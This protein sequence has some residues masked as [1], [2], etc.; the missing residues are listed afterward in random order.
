MARFKV[1]GKR[2]LTTI[3]GNMVSVNPGETLKLEG[4]W[5]NDRKF[6]EQFKV[7]RYETVIPATLMGIERYLGSGMIKGIGPV[8]ARR[9]VN[10]F[11]LDTLRIIEEESDKLL[12]VE[13]IGPVRVE[14]IMKAWGEQKEIRNVMLFLQGQGISSAYAVK[15]FK[16]YGNEAIAKVRENPYCLAMDVY[17]IGFKTA[18]K[19][20]ESLGVDKNSPLRAEAGLIYTLQQISDDGH[21][22]YPRKELIS[23]ASELLKIEESILDKAIV[24]LEAHNQIAVEADGFKGLSQ[25]SQTR[26]E[27]FPSIYL[28][29]L[30]AAEVGVAKRLKMLL[31]PPLLPM[32]IDWE[33]ALP[34]LENRMG[35]TLAV[36]QIEALKK[37][38]Q[39]RITVITGGPGTGK[40]TL[41]RCIV[42]ILNQ[43]GL[44]FLLTAP[45]GRAA[46]RLSEATQEDAKT[47]HR[48]LEYSPKDGEFKRN[49]NNPLPVEFLVVDE[50]SMVDIV[51]MNHLLKALPLG[52]SLIFVGDADQLPS[53]GP[54]NVLRDTI[55]SGK[56]EVVRL[57][58]IFRQARESLIVTNAHRINQ[59]VF[60]DLE[61]QQKRGD[62]FFIEK[63]DPEEVLELI[64]KM[65]SE[66]IPRRFGFKPLEDIQVL[67]PMNR[68]LLG[69]HNLNSELQRCLNPHAQE[70]TKSG[71]NFKL[72]DK[73]M[74][75]SNNYEKEVFNGDIGNV[76]RIDLEE[77]E[78]T[79]NF[80][81]RKVIYD[82]NDLDE[83]VVA[84][85]VS[86]HKSQ[87]SEYPAVI[88]PLLTQHYVM[89]QRNLLYTAVTRG[90]RLVVII[91]TKKAL[92]IALKNDRIRKRY[93][94]L[95]E[96]LEA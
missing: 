44:R 87:G 55:N 58:E 63:E 86:V 91:G 26:A 22:F 85:A 10:T 95:K 92:A 79:V 28:N 37:V 21:T 64:K 93:S 61:N 36:K 45:T 52:T 67:C 19:I 74:Q 53:V 6:G 1:E 66:R 29:A 16:T 48:L 27:E 18:D 24:N 70:L 83:L 81:D 60:P 7:E 25:T 9:L 13:G 84:Y 8:F 94:H 43:K 20:A 50:I 46:K 77:Q 73:V 14:R 54:G 12:E 42:M 38:F 56:A 41:V 78:L 17:G 15:I 39:S 69:T 32:S 4:Y 76:V 35:V 90:K 65:C 3:V 51:L 82:F 68:G 5:V 71:R 88:I 49:Q 40:T 34:W 33:K 57:T 96:R 23:K 11:G 89:L 75:I 62:F 47:I 59:G 80:E 72:N 2:D 30:H 31:T